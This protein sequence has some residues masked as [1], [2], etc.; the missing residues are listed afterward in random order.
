[1]TPERPSDPPR[2]HGWLGRG[3]FA[4]TDE[5]EGPAVVAIHGLPGS[6]RDYRW[7]GA[8]LAE[9]P[10]RFIRLEHPG[11]GR[12]PRATGPGYH[13][14]DRVAFAVEAADAMG[15]ER[16]HVLGH[17]IGGPVAMGL[18]AARPE[19]VATVA[20]LA[21]VGLHTHRLI[22]RTGRLPDLSRALDLPPLRAS[23]LPAL[24]AS[25]RRIGF[26]RS[27][28][29]EAIVHTMRI[30]S[31]LRFDEIR[32][33]ARRVR[34]PTLVAYAEDDALVEPAIALSLANELPSGGLL[35][36]PSGGHNIQKTRAVELADAIAACVLSHDW[37]KH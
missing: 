28:P 33:V 36:F 29:D 34:A 37:S 6:I 25:F 8:A 24:R 4:Y 1:M 20:L 21:S 15:L 31:A 26:P 12:T 3:P 16:F 35:G 27:T 10:V 7:L 17:S 18:A 13:L 11:F 32:E 5:G 19:R 23:L 14:A 9:H 2:Q 22:R 30:V